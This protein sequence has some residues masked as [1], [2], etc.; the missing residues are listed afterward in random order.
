MSPSNRTQ[1]LVLLVGLG[2]LIAA[3][4]AEA[5][6]RGRVLDP[7]RRSRLGISVGEVSSLDGLVAETTRRLLDVIGEPQPDNVEEFS[8]A[9]LG[10]EAEDTTFGLAYEYLWR[11]VTLQ[12]EATYVRAEADGVATRDFFIGVEDIFFD[13]QRYEYQVI[14]EG[15]PYRADVDSALVGLRANVTPVT[16]GAGGPAELVPW[17]GV[18]LFAFAGDFGVDA[19]PA[20]GVQQYELPVRDYVENGRGSGEVVAFVPELGVG[21]ELR[22]RLGERR[23]RPARLV[24]QG[25]YSIF[26]FKGSSS[27]LG[28]SARNDK[29]LDVDYTSLDARLLVEWPWTDG[30]DFVLGGGV[31][32]LEADAISAA[33][34]RDLADTLARREK[35][36]KDVNLEITSFNVLFGLRW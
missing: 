31:R 1:L 7:E 17:V 3:P 22:V 34:N 33:K 11:F 21:S 27:D 9:E 16:V 20:L 29:D 12:A 6:T 28:I 19:G 36:D 2:L 35:F 10:V 8:F 15:T 23:G 5:V 26:R 13:G 30:L 32:S 25:G 4:A 14:L 18:G 24:L